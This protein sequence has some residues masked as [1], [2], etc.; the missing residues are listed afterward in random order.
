MA[1]VPLPLIPPPLRLRVETGERDDGLLAFALVRPRLFGIA[2]RMLGIAAEAE[3]IAQD[4]WL[5]WQST[6]RN[7]VQGPPAYLATT[8]TRLCINLAQSAHNSN[9]Q[10]SP[11]RV[12]LFRGV[13]AWGP[14]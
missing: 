8:T 7:M 12:R 9:F 6:N 14:V 4:V 11:T 3:N 5:C 13:G 1:E 2:Y 10:K